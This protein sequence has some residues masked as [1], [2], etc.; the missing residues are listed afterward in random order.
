MLTMDKKTFYDK[1]YGCWMGKNI[2][3]TFGGPLEGKY[4]D[5][6]NFDFYTQT[7]DGEPM[8]NDDLDLQ[9]LNLH[10]VE[11][12]GVRITSRHLAKEWESHVF[13][14]MDEYGLALSNMRRGLTTPVSGHHNNFFTDCMGSPIRSEIWALMA[15]GNPD[16]AAYFAYQDACVD[17]AGGEGVFGEVF[18]AAIEAMAFTETNPYKL[19]EQALTYIPETSITARAIRDTM[20]YHKEG[21][22]WVAARTKLVESYHDDN[23]CFAPINIAFTMLG[24][25]WG[26]D[27]SEAICMATNCGYDTDCTAAT[28]GSILGIIHGFSYI[29][30]KWIEPIGTN[31]VTCPQVNGFR[32]PKNI[33]ELTE[34]TIKAHNI[35]M[36]EYDNCLDKDIFKIDY[37]IST[38]KF[39]VPFDTLAEKDLLVTIA[40]DD[41]HPSIDKNAKKDIYVCIQNKMTVD[42]YGYVGLSAPCGFNTSMKEWFSIK[43]GEVYTYNAAVI[44]DGNILPSYRCAVIIER[45]QTVTL[46]TTEKIDFALMPTYN[47]L[48]K[49]S[50]S[51]KEVRIACPTY[52][53]DFDKVFDT[54]TAGTTFTATTNMN[55]PIALDL[56]LTVSCVYPI[57]FWL[58]GEKLVDTDKCDPFLPA[59]HRPTTGDVKMHVPAGVH[60]LTITATKTD[61]LDKL[62]VAFQ[63]SKLEKIYN[64]RENLC[65]SIEINYD[66]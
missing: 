29:P 53:I 9:L 28:L 21:L 31:I 12:Y 45:Y 34:R 46:W 11:Q 14:N 8:E 23:F 26:K 52:E 65:E 7:F 60:T 64:H 50:E 32:I 61:K 57:T 66:C 40:F 25:Y 36:A 5:V 22:D 62:Q 33:E 2:G 18:F 20:K 6:T 55:V 3:G 24:L 10:A 30:K 19:T 44:S 47:W 39:G 15:A 4:W 27:F 13:F 16:L 38:I 58:D 51:D 41:G 42:Y 35:L 48:V 56:R 54:T 37:D 63:A 1:I 49:S 59:F 17:H 43:P